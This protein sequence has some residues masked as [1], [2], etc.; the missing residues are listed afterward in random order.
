MD[1]A[2]RNGIWV[3]IG[4]ALLGFGGI[5]LVSLFIWAQSTPN[6]HLWANLLFK[7]VMIVLVVLTVIG[8]YALLSPWHGLPL[9]RLRAERNATPLPQVVDVELDRT[10]LANLFNDHT[11]VQVQ[12]LI[13]NYLGKWTQVS[14][15]VDEIRTHNLQSGT[16]SNVMFTRPLTPDGLIDLK[17]NF[18]MSFN[19]QQWADRLS[20]LR[21]GAFITVHGKITRI[22]QLSIDLDDCELV[23]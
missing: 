18:F 17:P 2:A 5:A 1:T 20:I 9:P 14:G 13:A 16:R 10:Y 12:K 11:D 6:L 3:S 22:T 4:G 7:L 19:G 23:N 8:G 15:H 21:R